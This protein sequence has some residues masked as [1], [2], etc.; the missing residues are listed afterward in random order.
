MRDFPFEVPFL[1][2]DHCVAFVDCRGFDKVSMT[3]IPP[4]DLYIEVTKNV[5]IRINPK[6][7]IPTLLHTQAPSIAPYIEALSIQGGLYK[8]ISTVYAPLVR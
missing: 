4:V 8:P 5:R 6:T 7:L 1:T 2:K 3:Y